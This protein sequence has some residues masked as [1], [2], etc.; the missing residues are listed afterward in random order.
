MA[1]ILELEKLRVL[2]KYNANLRPR[3]FE[4]RR[5]YAGARLVKWFADVL[6]HLGS[7]WKREE[8]PEFQVA[9]LLKKYVTGAVLTY[10]WQFHT[11]RPF[12][13]SVWE[14]KT[15]DVRIFGWFFRKDHFIGVVADL[16]QN[17]LDH[18]GIASGYVGDVVRFRDR[19]DL[20]E[21]KLIE[22]K[23]PNNVVSNF[24]YPDR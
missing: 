12:E 13:N 4:D 17:I 16:K 21:P 22:G 9:Y 24:T 2:E 18:S 10:D 23:D 3:E 11:L 7:S 14:L 8:T 19:L 20:N 15:A 1:T 6:P 5:L